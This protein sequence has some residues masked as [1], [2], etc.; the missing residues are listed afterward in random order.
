MPEICRFYGIVIQLYYA[1]HAPPHF[2]AFYADQKIVIDIKTFSII[3]GHLQPRALG[4]V[5][6]WASM[7]QKELFLAFDQASQMMPPEKIEPLI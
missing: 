1:D 2:H 7:H 6:E 5:I 3:E 4:L